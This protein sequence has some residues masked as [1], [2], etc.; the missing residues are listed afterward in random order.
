[1]EI[2]KAGGCELNVELLILGLYW[3]FY[4]NTV[5]GS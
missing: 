5:A 2:F 4:R 3:R 1:M